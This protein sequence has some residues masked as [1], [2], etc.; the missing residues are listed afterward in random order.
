MHLLL[1]VPM[2]CTC[3]SIHIYCNFVYHLWLQLM[4]CVSVPNLAVFLAFCYCS[5]VCVSQK[6]HLWIIHTLQIVLLT[7]WYFICVHICVLYSIYIS[8]K[9]P[10]IAKNVHFFDMGCSLNAQDSLRS[11]W[12]KYCPYVYVSGSTVKPLIG[13]IFWGVLLQVL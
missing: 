11:R 8:F 2:Q 10:E 5:T 7:F 1:L 6:W 3:D 9:L 13:F 4:F 12:P